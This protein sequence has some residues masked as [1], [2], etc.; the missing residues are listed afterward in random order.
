[1]SACAGS[2]LA[3]SRGAFGHI[4]KRFACFV[5]AS[6]QYV[7]SRKTTQ[8]HSGQWAMNASVY[9][10]WEKPQNTRASI[11][12]M[13]LLIWLFCPAFC[14]ILSF[15]A[16]SSGRL[17]FEPVPSLTSSAHS[18]TK[19]KSFSVLDTNYNPWYID[20][21]DGSC[22][23]MIEGGSKWSGAERKEEII[24]T[25]T[26]FFFSP[27]P[28]NQESLDPWYA[29][30]DIPPKMWRPTGFVQCPSLVYRVSQHLHTSRALCHAC[31][32]VKL[33]LISSHVRLKT[34]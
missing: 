3:P 15:D 33:S 28:H 2:L 18:M 12:F 34:E 27:G 32:C 8:K 1:M 9:R 30:R 23:Q 31:S 21:A 17:L 11:V 16:T 26:F 29:H 14:C 4:I 25:T 24:S 13:F 19:I 5:Q 10:T 6:E 7:L 22:H 20:W